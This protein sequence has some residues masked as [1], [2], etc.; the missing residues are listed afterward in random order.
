M[1]TV[2]G[3]PVDWLLTVLRLTIL[4]LT[5]LRLTVHRLAVPRRSIAE[6]RRLTGWRDNHHGGR[7]LELRL[8]ILL[9]LATTVRGCPLSG[10]LRR[11]HLWTLL[12]GID[13]S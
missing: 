6:L 1:L 4:K 7:M 8:A 5:I 11:G 10:L 2:L 12:L 13:L 9:L 3:L